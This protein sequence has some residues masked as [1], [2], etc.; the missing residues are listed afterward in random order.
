MFWPAAKHSLFDEIT[1]VPCLYCDADVPAGG[2]ER[3]IEVVS[4][5]KTRAAIAVGQ[6]CSLVY[7]SLAM[8]T[9]VHGTTFCDQPPYHVTSAPTE[10]RESCSSACSSAPTMCGGSI[11]PH[12][13]LAT[14]WTARGF[15]YPPNWAATVPQASVSFRRK[16]HASSGN[17]L[18]LTYPTDKVFR[19]N[20]PVWISKQEAS[21]FRQTPTRQTKKTSTTPATPWSQKIQFSVRQFFIAAEDCV[22]L[23]VDFSQIEMRVVAHFSKDPA[24][25]HAFRAGI[26]VFN[27]MAARIA[28]LTKGNT[29]TSDANMPLKS[30]E[31]EA[32]SSQDR[33][34]A[35]EVCYSILYGSGD[36]VCTLQIAVLLFTVVTMLFTYGGF[37]T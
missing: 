29:T 6:A 13:P 20:A 7:T 27:S 8:L 26:D 36:K 30:V 31:V 17:E 5:S 3:R 4:V 12:K 14:Y 18:K 35:K 11:D 1:N 15:E 34:A 9:R 24:L 22:L 33:K 16:A 28:R 10:S 2:R 37:A 32:V 25:L 23:S 21:E 19:T